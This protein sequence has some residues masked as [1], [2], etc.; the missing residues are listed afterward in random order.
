MSEYDYSYINPNKC[1]I[2]YTIGRRGFGKST[3]SEYVCS[4]LYQVGWT[5][6]DIWASDN[7]EN[8]FTCISLNCKDN[9]DEVCNCHKAFPITLLAPANITFDQNAVDRFNKQIYTQTEW[10]KKF[11]NKQFNLAYPPMKPASE[12]PKPLVKIVKL[13]KPTKTFKTEQNQKIADI[14]EQTVL[15]CRKNRRYLVF[16]PKMYQDEA[17]SFRILEVLI[18]KLNDI[19]YRHFHKLT[20]Q[21]VGKS[22]R[23]EMTN[24]EKCY[25]KMV[26]LV[27]EMGELAPSSK[28]K[29]D[30]SGESVKVKK[31]LLMV[32]R[33]LRHHQISLQTDFQNFTDCESSIRNQLDLLT[34]VN[35]TKR[36]GGD[37]LKW[38]FDEIENRNEA[39]KSKYGR[40]GEQYAKQ[41]QPL[42]N[43]LEQGQAYVVYPNDHIRLWDIPMPPFHHKNPD[44]HW[45]QITGITFGWTKET[46]SDNN[47][48][49]G[50][51][52]EKLLFSL[53]YEKKNPKTGKG[54]KWNEILEY[55]ALEQQKGTIV[56][57]KQ[58]KEMKNGTIAKMFE[59]WLKRYEKT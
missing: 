59:R 22:S 57:D 29:S 18:R 26:V 9:P 7:L 16:N 53:I 39:I 47:E 43:E 12:R 21:D 56:W 38:V 52:D 35:T 31:A 8:A 17:D 30:Q 25:D 37:E 28:L 48:N 24:Q 20:P 10:Y 27:R 46:I 54:L 34:L 51:T 42:V 1:V 55:L 3:Y 45:E 41:W 32:V 15:D 44:Q 23:S 49:N 36:L 5:V 2:N 14:F 50:K 4:K 13:P 40:K 6:L 58:F 33:K 11:P 19:A